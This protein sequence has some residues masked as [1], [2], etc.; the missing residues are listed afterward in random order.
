MIVRPA[1]AASLVARTNMS[2]NDVVS[3]NDIINERGY[4]QGLPS[5]EATDAPQVGAAAPARRDTPAAVS[6][7]RRAGRRRRASRRGRWPTAPTANRCRTRSPMRRS[8]PRSRA[9]VRFR[10][11]T[12]APRAAAPADTTIV[13]KRSDDRAVGRSAGHA[14]ASSRQRRAGRRPLQRSVDA[15]HDREPE[16]AE[17]HE[18]DAVRRAGLPQSRSVHAEAGRRP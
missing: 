3:A 13:A 15:R 18:N 6:R 2:A 16:R 7:Q 4:W 8:R 12:G 9:P 1:Q 5:A 11:V 17:L 14:A 10:W